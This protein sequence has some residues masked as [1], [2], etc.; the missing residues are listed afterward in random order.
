MRISFWIITAFRFLQRSGPITAVLSLMLFSAISSLVFLSSLSVGINDA[1][2]SN[3]VNMYSGHI[4]GF[5]LPESISRQSLKTGGVK[6][7]LKRVRTPGMISSPSGRAEAITLVGIDP[8]EEV[9]TTALP[10]KTIAG[11]PPEKGE[12]ALF[13]GKALADSLNVTTGD[14][15]F[16][17]PPAWQSPL[18][19]SVCGIFETGIFRFDKS[20]AFCPEQALPAEARAWEAAVFLEDGIKTKDI[21]TFYQNSFPKEFHFST[22]EELMPDLRQLI[23]LNVVSMSIVI[24]LVFGVVSI[25]IACGLVIF[26]LKNMR[27]YGIMKAMGSTAGELMLLIYAKV[28]LITLCT[29][30]AGCLAGVLMVW[31]GRKTGIDLTA[32]TSH[33]QYFAVSGIIYPR[34]TLFSLGAPPVAALFFSLL[35][36]AWP[37]A[38]LLRKKTAEILRSI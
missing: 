5:D 6:Q 29:S 18:R 24:V 1:M 12:S 17:N 11:R 27:E 4:T 19:L 35:A 21:L 23:D 10:E 15:V 38:L 32:F 7:V 2:I 26:I 25:G 8:E 28:I 22:W 30:L 33:N 14:I 13:L 16:F 20:L 3:S 31:G 34:L 37:V 9:R 36:A